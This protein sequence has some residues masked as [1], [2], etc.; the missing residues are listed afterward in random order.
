MLDNFILKYG[1]FLQRKSDQGVEYNIEILKKIAKILEV[2]QAFATYIQTI[3]FLERNQRT[4]NEYLIAFTNE[5]SDDQ[6]D[7]VKFYEFNYNTT[8]H[9]EKNYT[10]YELVFGK[11]ANLP[12]DLRSGNIENSVQLCVYFKEMKY[13]LQKSHEIARK[14]CINQKFKMQGIANVNFKPLD[15]TQGVVSFNKS[16]CTIKNKVTNK[17]STVHQNSVVGSAALLKPFR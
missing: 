9:T 11:K 4:L 1:K 17:F 7:W 10:P 15:V 16:N 5:H 13:K 3:G 12:Q 8:P 6:D 14:N 2:K